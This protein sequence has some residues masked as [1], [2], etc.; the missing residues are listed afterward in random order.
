MQGQEQIDRNAQ[1]DKNAKGNNK[2]NAKKK[3]KGG[4]KED[5]IIF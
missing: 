5:C 1:S 4:N 2:K 3:G